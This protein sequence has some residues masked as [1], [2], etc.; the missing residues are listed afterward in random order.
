MKTPGFSSAFY[1]ILP[2]AGDPP[3]GNL[4]NPHPDDRRLHQSRPGA[5]AGLSRSFFI[6]ASVSV[7]FGRRWIET[8]PLNL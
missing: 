2:F 8:V 1:P 4:V 7:V 3:A 5:D 6:A